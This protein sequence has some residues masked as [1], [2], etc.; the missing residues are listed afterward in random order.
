MIDLLVVGAGLSGLMTAYRA[1]L[2]GRSVKVIAKG[3]GALHWS[4]ATI[5]VFGYRADGALVRHPLQ[6]IA[7]LAATRPDHPYALLGVDQTRAAL[8]DFLALTA[9]AGLPYSG[10]TNDGGAATASQNMLLPSPA[11]AV[12]PTLLA[13]AAQL[14]GDLGR[15]EPLLIIGFDGMRDFY[16]AL[17]AENLAKQGFAARAALLPFDLLSDRR[18]INTIQLA[19]ALDDE[20]RYAHLAEAVR[21]VVQ[22]GERVGLPA[23]L[24]LDAHAAVLEALQTTA[25][26]P[27]FEIPTLPPS[28]P[29]VRLFKVLCAELERLGVRVEAGMEVIGTEI[30]LDDDG[31]PPRI[32]WV[33]SETSARPLRH[34]A[35]NFVLATGGILGG[36]FDSDPA[37]RV[38]ETIFDLPLTA[39]QARSDWFHPRFLDERGHP[40]FRGGVAVN[41]TMQPI[42]GDGAPRFANLRVAGSTLAGFDPI[43]ERS[44][45]GVAIAS[46]IAAAGA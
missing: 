26:A 11:G 9:Q 2:A 43:V 4:A 39:P 41:H 36:G 24:G 12:R 16:P 37:G 34:R 19:T 28:V 13:P 45:E 27:V 10:A 3:L 46:G 35:E 14:A 32:A 29:G 20:A 18:D 1:A 25:D 6:E 21:D 38:W 22:P 42:D 15:T 17:I 44:M 30:A 5:D 8:D 23:I 31:G 40:V 33:A 7:G